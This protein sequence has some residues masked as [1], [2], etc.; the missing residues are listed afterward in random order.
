[1]IRLKAILLLVVLITSITGSA[2]EKHYCN[3]NLTDISWFGNVGCEMLN[4]DNSHDCCSSSENEEFIKES[5]ASHLEKL[6][7]SS[8]CETMSTT[9]LVEETKLERLNQQQLLVVLLI[10]NNI[11]LLLNE[12]IPISTTIDFNVDRNFPKRQILYQ[13]FLI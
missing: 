8:C 1:V 5:C 11:N 9:I 10:S 6:N 12:N 4:V 13:N 3:G 7:C 2:L